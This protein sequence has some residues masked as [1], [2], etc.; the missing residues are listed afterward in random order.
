MFG[1]DV[2]LHALAPADEGTELALV[3]ALLR[4]KVAVLL[5]NTQAF[6]LTHVHLLPNTI[7]RS[8]TG[9]LMENKLFFSLY[10]PYLT[11]AN[12]I[13][14]VILKVVGTEMNGGV[15]SGLKQ[16]LYI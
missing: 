7:E 8:V 13:G 3:L 5:R 1:Q 10:K 9:V 14:T 2:S 11:T 4:Q 15:E 16:C 6:L 12:L